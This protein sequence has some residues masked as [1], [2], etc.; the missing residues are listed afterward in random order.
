MS[1]AT[2]LR[3]KAEDLLALAIKAREQG[4]LG[5]ADT[6]VAEATRFVNDAD[7]LEE[8]ARSKERAQEILP[9]ARHRPG[10]T[11]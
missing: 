6:L 10:G 3:Q 1:E 5:Y 11:G 2:E 7:A 9:S 8:A 4:Q